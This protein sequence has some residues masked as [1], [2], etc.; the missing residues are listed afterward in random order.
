MTSLWPEVIGSRKVPVLEKGRGEGYKG[1][2]RCAPCLVLSHPLKP[3]FLIFWRQRGNGRALIDESGC[4]G[5][6]ASVLNLLC[7]FLAS[8]TLS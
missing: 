1:V 4:L 7:H 8:V 2:L 3:N 6:G 5:E